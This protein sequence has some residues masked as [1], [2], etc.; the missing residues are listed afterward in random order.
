[1]SAIVN[2]AA[3]LAERA[4]TSPDAVALVEQI[5]TNLGAIPGPSYT[6]AKLNDESHRLARGLAK[7]GVTRG[8]RAVLMVPPSLAS[9]ALTFA[10]LELGAVAV[11][12]DPGMGVKSLGVCLDEAEP[13]AFIGVPKAHAARVLLGW[14]RKTIRHRVTVGWRLFWGGCTLAQVAKAGEQGEPIFAPTTADE[15]AAILFT[16]GSTGVAKG[17]VYT[18]GIFAAQVA[19]LRS[20]YGIEA[21]EVDLP[22]FPLF[23]L[24]G[25]ALG[26]ASVIP[27]MDFTRPGRVEP[28]NVCAPLRYNRVTNLFGS[29]ALLRRVFFDPEIKVEDLKTLRRVISAGAPVSAKV[30]RRVVELLPPGVQVHTPY[31]ATE[32][33]PV[34][35]IASDEI[36]G[37][38]A[39]L[40]EQGRGV[41]VGRPVEG[42]SVRIVRISDE[43]IPTWSDDLLLPQG[44]I[45]EIV[46]RGPVVTRS[47]HNRP[48]MTALHKIHDGGDLWHRMGDVGYLDERGRLWFCG[49][50][51]QRVVTEQG[52]FFT[53]CCE[54]V[55]NAHPQVFRTAL[56]GVRRNG[57]MEPELCVEID[58]ELPRRQRPDRDVSSLRTFLGELAE[59]GSRH[60]HTR[61]IRRFHVH[62]AFPV[63][64]RH[65]AKIFREKLAAW[66]A[67]RS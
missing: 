18:H 43:P 48:D 45:G 27:Q 21:G 58:P 15:T 17:A 60:D 31:G 3:A 64:I 39:A 14:G 61:A 42:M 65:N 50:K 26:M 16:S 7:L 5:P 67:T 10:L 24:F 41:C 33:L 6:Y 51:S 12:I 44:Q 30:I 2:V 37:E 46:V 34:A 62:G 32:A 22:T 1:M 66:A 40:T 9:Y 57:K 49:R 54:G 56:V 53:I 8:M 59:L 28:R 20:L 52:T 47:Y 63:D 11:L 4:R 25:P 23:G 38:T 36:L 29:P 35:T 19:Y 55:F 13:E